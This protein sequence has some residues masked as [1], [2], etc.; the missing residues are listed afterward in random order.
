M[1]KPVTLAEFGILQGT[2]VAM[3]CDLLPSGRILGLDIDLGHING[4][5]ANLT[6]LGAFTRNRPELHEYDQFLDDDASIGRI[7]AGAKIDIAI[8]DGFHSTESIMK[9]LE[10]ARPHL[11]D[12]FVYFAEDNG[13]V[14]QE[15]QSRYPEFFI[16]HAGDL[17]VITRRRQIPLSVRI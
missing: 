5:M 15:I 17:T 14:H 7:L 10:S 13:H 4:N 6:A 3:W 2:G 11:A 16:D 8:D 9:T 12:E 1:K